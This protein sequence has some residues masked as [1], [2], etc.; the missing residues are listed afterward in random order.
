MEQSQQSSTVRVA[1]IEDRREIREGLSMLIG[2]TE[3]F[4][5]VGKYGSM[6]EALA[7]MRHR[8]PDVVLSDIGL[9]GMDGIEGIG[10]I[11]EQHPEVTILML[12]VYEDNERIFEALCA[13]AVGYLLKNTPPAKILDAIREA[14]GGGSPM[15]PEVARKVITVFRN[16]RP[17]EKVNYDLTPHE[18]RLLKLLVDGHSY[19][20]AARDLGVSVNTVSFHLKSIYE[21][22]QVHSKSEAVAKAFRDGLIK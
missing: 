4:E 1:I 8:A 12:S 16:Y 13:G 18:T 22:L 7:S 19:K 11:K 15:S 17:P 5:C 14:L 6:E 3:G 10:L 9:P 2:F 21:K 20:T